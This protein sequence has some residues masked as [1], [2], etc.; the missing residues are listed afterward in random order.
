MAS[1][2]G[3]VGLLLV[4]ESHLKLSPVTWRQF[5]RKPCFSS[6]GDAR[7]HNH[8]AYTK[9]CYPIGASISI[10]FSISSPHFEP[11]IQMLKAEYEH[12][13]E[14]NVLRH[15]GSSA[16]V[17]NKSANEPD[18]ERQASQQLYETRNCLDSESSAILSCKP[19]LQICRRLPVVPRC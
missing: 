9:S 12:I 6:E 16:H 14:H 18:S 5:Q 8:T 11:I 13:A 4:A 19:R 2:C 1:D 17:A 3:D 10:A 7:L 15:P